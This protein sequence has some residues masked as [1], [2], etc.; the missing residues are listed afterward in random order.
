MVGK[1]RGRGVEGGLP[2]SIGEIVYEVC[3]GWRLFGFSCLCAEVDGDGEGD[4]GGGLT[5]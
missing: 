2:V 1:R 3:R 5:P 4:G